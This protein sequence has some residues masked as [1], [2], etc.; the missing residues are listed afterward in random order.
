METTAIND[1]LDDLTHEELTRL[2]QYH[3]LH[4]IPVKR[5]SIKS[6]RNIIGKRSK[7]D[8]PD[9][10]AN[11]THGNARGNCFDCEQ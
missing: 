11:C 7:V 6:F 9:L 5:S 8:A 2:V 1:L 4:Q 10:N 3:F